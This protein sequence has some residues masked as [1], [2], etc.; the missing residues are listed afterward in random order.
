MSAYAPSL[1][2]LKGNMWSLGKLR[3]VPNAARPSTLVTCLSLAALCLAALTA[4]AVLV[5]HRPL[6]PQLAWQVPLSSRPCADFAKDHAP[7]VWNA[8]LERCEPDV[9][10][11]IRLTDL[12]D[13][14]GEVAAN[15]ACNTKLYDAASARLCLRGKTV[16][17]LGD[18][19]MTETAHDFAILLS[20]IAADPELMADYIM[21]V[22][23]HPAHLSAL[24]QILS[25]IASV[26]ST[27]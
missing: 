18:S 5:G 26:I 17:L 7:V 19:T 8:D 23:T 15:V 21:N 14:G 11:G 13:V 9:C 25:P 4:L 27:A 20:G 6:M 24:E 12:A 1:A 16:L 10:R 3:G 2:L 22:G